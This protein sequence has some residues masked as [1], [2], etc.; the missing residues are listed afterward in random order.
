WT[1]DPSLPHISAL[2]QSHPERSSSCRSGNQFPWTSLNAHAVKPVFAPSLTPRVFAQD[3]S[4]PT[5]PLE[6]RAGPELPLNNKG[7]RIAPTAQFFC[8][9]PRCLATIAHEAEQEQ[10]H[11]EE[12]EVEV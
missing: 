11:V 12:V 1:S 10:E 5:H 6:P 3:R 9:V 2:R 4:C 7:R 8:A